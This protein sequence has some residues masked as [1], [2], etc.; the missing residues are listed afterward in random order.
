MTFSLDGD[1]LTETTVIEASAG[2][3]KTYTIVGLAACYVAEG[4]TLSQLMLVTFGRAATQELR[5]RARE[6]FRRSADALAD[7]GAARDSDD[8][9]IRVLATGTDDDVELRRARLQ[10]AVSDFDAATI[11]TTHSFCQRMLDGIGVAGDYEPHVTYRD[12]TAD[13]LAD[14]TDDLYAA[15]YTAAYPPDLALREARAVARVAVNDAQAA[16]VPA[17]AATGSAAAQRVTFAESARA[18]LTARKRASAVRDYNDMLVLLR[19]ALADPV[20]GEAACARVRARFRVVLVD[21]FQDTDPLQW[22]ILRRAFH[23]WV[24][25]VLVGDPKQAI[26][27]FRGAD[28]QTYLGA[29][30]IAGQAEVLAV[31]RRTDDGLVRALDHLYGGAAL[32]DDSI[33]VDPVEAFHAECRMP[34]AAPLRMRYLHRAG[35]GLPNVGPVRERIAGDVADDI[36][37]TLESGTQFTDDGRVRP[38][39]PSDIAVLV[40]SRD[41]G[42]LVCDALNRAQVPCVLTGGSSVFTT[43]AATAWARLL[44]ALDQP[45]R[46]ERLRLAALSP[47]LGYTAAELAAGGDGLPAQLSVQVRGWADAFTTRGLAAMFEL[48]CA[49]SDLAARLLRVQGGN[50]MA[51]DLR[52]LA[53]ILNRAAET[54]SLGLAALS[55]WLQQRVDDAAFTET[56]DRNRLLDRDTAAVRVVTVH[57]SKGLEFPVVYLP[58]GWD[59]YVRRKPESLLLHL[60]GARVRDVGGEHG[61]G[62]DERNTLH[63]AEDA[64]EELRLLYVAATR[65]QCRVVAWWAPSKNTRTS[66]LHRMLFGRD[67]VSA[68]PAPNPE[69]PVDGAVPGLLADWAAPVADVVGIEAV[70]A[71]SAGRVWSP[72]GGP[73]PQL[74]L[75]A[76]DRTLTWRWQRTSFS[77]LT[78]VE[79]GQPAHAVE[80]DEPGTVDE[81]DAVV[82]A[83]G[84]AQSQGQAPSLM[85]GLP[86]G[87]SFGTLVHSVLQQV[88]TSASVLD[89]EIAGRCADA[90]AGR[91]PFEQIP[92]LAAALSAV[93]RTPL[94]IGTLASVAPVDRL[95]ELEFELPLAGGGD[96]TEGPSVAAIADLVRTH[97]PADDVLASYPQ[98]LHTLPNAALRGYLNGSIDA[99]LRVDGPRYVVVDYKTNQLAAGTVDATAFDRDAM[100]VEMARHHYP[101]QALLYSVALHRYLRWR[102]PGYDPGIHLGGVWYLFL[103]GMI[104]EATPPGCGVF[105]WDLPPSLVV[106]L[107]DLLAVK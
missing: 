72:D 96:A 3:G 12:T 13:L 28:V 103:R 57:M 37:A 91:L 92:V 5:D 64:G 52:H 19:D 67:A 61:P 35:S 26:Y 80:I 18:T 75:A 39:R 36:V 33:R 98:V 7:P 14:V 93:M 48:L 77:R 86:G 63:E 102:Q 84:G 94:P 106:G 49:S 101:L 2:T 89:A 70:P 24:T 79:P 87:K 60:D 65:A 6:L 85:N 81:P 73:S 53:Q 30:A 107:S 25:L 51:T 8:D 20:Y 100:A 55:R 71:V 45:H 43:P 23:G 21:E 83:P 27:A 22:E 104:G 66:P 17:D 15:G 74:A 9:V 56:E 54:E 46:P 31:N 44:A 78:R 76:F 69:V 34:G 90:A 10:R 62:Y 59:R 32:G 47:L 29:V 4:V 41:N 97:L 38:L 68:H 82:A 105:T 95:V 16:L 99:V 1:L 40:R 88:D 50:R 11:A 58:F 42:R